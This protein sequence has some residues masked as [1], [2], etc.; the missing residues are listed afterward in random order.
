M[1]CRFGLGTWAM[2]VTTGMENTRGGAALV[3]A[4][5]AIIL[6]Q[7]V[8]SVLCEILPERDIKSLRS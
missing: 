2:V 1:S 8:V 5:E 7:R 4:D 3:G 6:F